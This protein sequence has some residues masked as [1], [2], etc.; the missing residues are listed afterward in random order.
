MAEHL[1][2]NYNDVQHG[3]RANDFYDHLSHITAKNNAEAETA[4]MREIETQNKQNK[5]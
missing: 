2:I 5:K 4:R 1:G 3:I